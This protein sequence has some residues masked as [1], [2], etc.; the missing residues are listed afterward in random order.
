M[1]DS[2]EQAE[3]NRNEKATTVH[4]AETLEQLRLE[5]L[6]LEN[7]NAA[8]NEAEASKKKSQ[9]TTI[10]VVVVVVIVLAVGG[11]GLF[12]IGRHR[13]NELAGTSNPPAAVY[14]NPVY[15][16]GG[17]APPG[18]LAAGGESKGGGLI[19]QESMC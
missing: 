1:K 5:Q 18:A 6:R 13:L 17:A 16:A 2:A 10:V 19:R 4:D 3:A 9:T 14:A 8:Q 12:V 7:A 15:A 11:I